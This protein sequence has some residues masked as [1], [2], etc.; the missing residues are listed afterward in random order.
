MYF[1]NFAKTYFSTIY[2]RLD[3]FPWY[4]KLGQ[5]KEASLLIHKHTINVAVYKYCVCLT[6]TCA[7]NHFPY[8][9]VSCFAVSS[10]RIFMVVLNHL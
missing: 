8:I 9:C 5:L 7:I 10:T 4:T 2:D 3:E 1:I 6:R